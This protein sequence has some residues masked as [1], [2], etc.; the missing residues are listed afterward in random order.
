MAKIAAQVPALFE[1]FSGMNMN[2]LLGRVK[3]LKA[4]KTDG[5]ASKKKSAGA[6]SQ[7]Q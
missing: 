2:E 3:Q 4:D 1:A 7:T 5:D 6:G